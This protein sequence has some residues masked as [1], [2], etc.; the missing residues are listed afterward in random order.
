MTA[1]V[2]KFGTTFINGRHRPAALSFTKSRIV[3]TLE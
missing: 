2:I 3:P 1:D